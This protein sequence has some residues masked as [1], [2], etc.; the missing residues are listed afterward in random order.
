MNMGRAGMAWVAALGGA[1]GLAPASLATPPTTFN[2]VVEAENYSITQERQKIYDTPEYQAQLA[3]Q[4]AKNREEATLEQ[5]D[6]PERFFTDDLCWEGENGCA[7]DVRL[8]NWGRNGTGS[9]VACFSTRAMERRSPV[10]SGRRSPDLRG[11]RG[12]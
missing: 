11:V 9:C 5:G 8:Y 3:L 1:L 4:G 12:S 2:P 7:G 6:D 10:V